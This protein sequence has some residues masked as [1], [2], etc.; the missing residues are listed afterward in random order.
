MYQ[1]SGNWKRRTYALGR[2][3]STGLDQDFLSTSAFNDRPTQFFGPANEDQL[4][5]IGFSFL[6]DLPWGFRVNT[7]TKINSGL[8]SSMFLPLTSGGADEIYYS[9]LDGD[10]VTED[11]LTGRTVARLRRTGSPPRG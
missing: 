7:S 5:E 2:F 9:D 8:A 11:P 1:R 10:G 3:E 6:A 4:H